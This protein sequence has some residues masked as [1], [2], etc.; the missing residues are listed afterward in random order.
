[1]T[2]IN[3]SALVPYSAEQMYDLVDNIPAYAEFL[4][5]CQSAEE[6]QR[7]ENEV[8][9]SLFI[10]HSGLKKS[11]TTR[12]TLDKPNRIT[13]NLVEGPFKHLQGVWTFS[14]LGD[15]G[16]KVTLDMNFE[17]SS[18]LMGLTFGPVFS[19]MAN[20]LVDA[21]VQRANDIYGK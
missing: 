8:Q 20:S 19:H 9:G 10:A 17:F 16:C 15:E 21:F 2:K 1:M 12:N 13:M 7:N 11:F 14:P 3:K 4:P 18:K 6:L 5:W